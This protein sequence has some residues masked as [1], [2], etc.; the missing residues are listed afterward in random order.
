[1]RHFVMLIEIHVHLIRVNPGHI[2]KRL[3]R[4]V[5]NKSIVQQP[6]EELSKLL[7]PHFGLV[8]HFAHG[9]HHLFFPNCLNI[10]LIF[11]WNSRQFLEW[12]LEVSAS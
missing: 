1:M 5:T 3:I 10:C 7:F 2:C 6:V 8:T 4:I 12:K 11:L 9:L